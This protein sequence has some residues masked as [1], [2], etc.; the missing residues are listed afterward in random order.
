MHPEV[1]SR[2]QQPRIRTGLD[3]VKAYVPAGTAGSR[4]AARVHHLCDRLGVPQ[5]RPWHAH[6]RLFLSFGLANVPVPRVERV[7]RALSEIRARVTMVEIALDV[8]GVDGLVAAQLIVPRLTLRGR[9]RA[10]IITDERGGATYFRRCRSSKNVVSYFDRASK[11][12]PDGPPALHVELRLRTRRELEVEE[13]YEPLGLLRLT[14]PKAA[15]V[16][17]TKH[18]DLCDVDLSTV[19]RTERRLLRSQHRG[20]W[21]VWARA[22]CVHRRFGQQAFHAG[23]L[24][25]VPGSSFAAKVGAVLACAMVTQDS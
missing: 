11:V 18:V 7:L 15:D 4:D 17:L 22:G 20:P 8:T 3:G 23:V 10:P 21:E 25:S 16:V 2:R 19:A 9:M 12:D 5:Y 24:V 14:E 13:L 1:T 6:G